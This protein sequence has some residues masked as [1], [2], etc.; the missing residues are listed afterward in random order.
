MEFRGEG[1]NPNCVKNTDKSMISNNKVILPSNTEK[2][3]E[4]DRDIF[5]MAKKEN[6]KILKWLCSLCLK[7]SIKLIKFIV[8]SVEHWAG[9]SGC[10]SLGMSWKF[11]NL[12]CGCSLCCCF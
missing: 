11:K 12:F 7:V 4:G 8:D 5:V 3:M 1:K 6:E 9:G 10:K 2:R